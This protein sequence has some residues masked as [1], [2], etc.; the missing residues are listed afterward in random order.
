MNRALN[1]ATSPQCWLIAFAHHIWSVHWSNENVSCWQ[2]QIHPVIVLLYCSHVCAVDS[3]DNVRKTGCR[4]KLRFNVG[5][6][7]YG[8]LI[9]LADMRIIP[10]HTAGMARLRVDWHSPDRSASSLWNAP[11]A[12]EP[13]CGQNLYGY[14]QRMAPRRVAL[15]AAALRTVPGG[16]ASGT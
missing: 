7:R 16:Q 12:K 8:N 9:Y 6:F 5:L 4:C 10:S 14:R 3:S 15:P 2:K 11:G 13:Q 1:Q